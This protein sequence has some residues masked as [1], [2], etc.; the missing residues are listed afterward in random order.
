MSCGTGVVK[1]E[2]KGDGVLVP[3]DC[4]G[5]L[6][7]NGRGPDEDHSYQLVIHYLIDLFIEYLKE[8][9]YFIYI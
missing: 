1:C 8:C 5:V 6:S 4:G 3:C 9:I 2:C 7:V